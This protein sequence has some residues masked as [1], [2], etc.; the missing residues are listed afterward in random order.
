MAS[1]W[2]QN[3]AD[4]G[5]SDT[6]LTA[7][8]GFAETL[9]VAELNPPVDMLGSIAKWTVRLDTVA[10]GYWTYGF[11]SLD[12]PSQIGALRDTGVGPFPGP[13]PVFPDN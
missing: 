1:K 8:T 4:T 9:L 6:Q 12:D 13:H 3:V 7:W 5:M 2:R 10:P 11:P